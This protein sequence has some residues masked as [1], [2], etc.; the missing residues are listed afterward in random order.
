MK[1]LINII[2]GLAIAIFFSIVIIASFKIIT[3]D[4][5]NEIVMESL[6]IRYSPTVIGSILGIALSR[7]ITDKIYEDYSNKFK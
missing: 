1:I 6:L 2:I 4:V 7:I 5:P 3:Q